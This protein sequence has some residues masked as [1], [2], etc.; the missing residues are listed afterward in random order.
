MIA[1]SPIEDVEHLLFGHFPLTGD[2]NRLICAFLRSYLEHEKAAKAAGTIIFEYMERM[3]GTLR[4]RNALRIAGL[5]FPVV[6]TVSVMV[7]WVYN[8]TIG[9]FGEGTML[10]VAIM[11]IGEAIAARNGYSMEVKPES[12]ENIPEYA[13]RD[14]GVLRLRSA[15]AKEKP[16]DGGNAG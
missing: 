13:C 10:T 7:G 6:L 8:L 14:H 2:R 5:A 15:S 1:L 3:K 12:S 9:G 4:L 16:K 11:L